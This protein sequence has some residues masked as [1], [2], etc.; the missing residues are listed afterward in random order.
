MFL[1]PIS[2]RYFAIY[3][4][5]YYY[6]FVIRFRTIELRFE[7]INISRR[8]TCCIRSYNIKYTDLLSIF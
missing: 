5:Y 2:H 1:H 7:T 4:Y 8:I 3:Y 6:F